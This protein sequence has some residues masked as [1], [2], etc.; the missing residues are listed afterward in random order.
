MIDA[1]P[2]AAGEGLHSWT[3][4]DLR[5]GV[6]LGDAAKG[7]EFTVERPGDGTTRTVTLH[8]DTDLGVPTVGVTSPFSLT[9]PD[10]LS[11]GLPGAAGKAVPPLE[12]GDTIRGV[13]GAPVRTYA[14]L[15]SALARHPAQPAQLSVE[16]KGAAVT[17][18][19]PPQPAESTGL[20]MGCGPIKAVQ[21]DSPA[22][23]AGI[24]P[25]DILK[26]VDGEPIGDPLTLD[27]RLRERELLAAFLT[28]ADASLP[29]TAAGL[30]LAS[31]LVLTERDPLRDRERELG[32]FDD[33]LCVE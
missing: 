20:V 4:A 9:L 13:D 18:E 24:V 33:C 3:A 11:D 5:N 8:P 30:P 1:P 6:T 12:G 25:G 2:N 32:M 14:E 29:A 16:R 22:A 7:V 10:E 23:A 27:E 15:I 31:G 17:V 19:L 28:A 26:S 21:D